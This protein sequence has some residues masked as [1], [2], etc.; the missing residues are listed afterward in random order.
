M[1]AN[2]SVNESCFSPVLQ[3]PR[4]VNRA[5]VM[6]MRAEFQHSHQCRN[7][8]Y[9]VRGAEV[10]LKAISTGLIT[11]PNCEVTGPINIQILSNKE[12]A[13]INAASKRKSAV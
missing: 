9:V 11:C 4:D 5:K 7:C 1:K 10:D 8:N 2:P 6:K 3:F 12:I 13:D